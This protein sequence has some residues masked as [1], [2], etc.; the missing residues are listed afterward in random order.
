MSKWFDGLLPGLHFI[1]TVRCSSGIIVRTISR[2]FHTPAAEDDCI[3]YL[4][5]DGISYTGHDGG[6]NAATVFEWTSTGSPDGYT[7]SIDNGAATS[8]KLFN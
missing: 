6:G 7:C 1:L 5:N 3:P 2:R 8:C 4:I